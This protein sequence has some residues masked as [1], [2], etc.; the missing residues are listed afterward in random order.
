MEKVNKIP[1]NYLDHEINKPLTYNYHK[2]KLL[3]SYHGHHNPSISKLSQYIPYTN[4]KLCYDGSS[5]LPKFPFD[6]SVHLHEPLTRILTP[7]TM[8]I[9]R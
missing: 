4:T 7:Y 3:Y 6:I 2:N 9:R 8:V 1:T 5:N